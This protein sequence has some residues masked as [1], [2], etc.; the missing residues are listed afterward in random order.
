MMVR[1]GSCSYLPYFRLHN[2]RQ[3]LISLKS[4]VE[5]CIAF[6]QFF[7]QSAASL[8]CTARCNGTVTNIAPFQPA[9]CNGQKESEVLLFSLGHCIILSFLQASA[10]AIQGQLPSCRSKSAT[11]DKITGVLPAGPS[12]RKPSY[13][14]AANWEQSAQQMCPAVHLFAAFLF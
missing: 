10:L 11:E 9:Y 7:P 14:L 6:N 4:K 1:L 12:E 2:P 13:N 8:Q 3:Y 5:V